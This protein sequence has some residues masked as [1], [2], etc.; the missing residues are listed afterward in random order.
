VSEENEKTGATTM[1]SRR[2]VL[3]N[4]KS[5]GQSKDRSALTIACAASE[6]ASGLVTNEQQSKMRDKDRVRVGVEARVRD[7][8]WIDQNF[9][10]FQ[11]LS[12][13]V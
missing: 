2:F 7:R 5:V 11:R 6:W 8:A 3:A 10:L 1:R 9:F 12:G 4:V 13:P